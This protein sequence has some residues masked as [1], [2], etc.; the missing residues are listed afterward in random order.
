MSDWFNRKKCRNALRFAAL[1]FTF[2]FATKSYARPDMTPLG[3][4][5]ADKGSSF[6]HF[7]V[8]QFDS[9]DGKRHYRVWTGVPN[10]TPPASGFPILYLLDGNAVM[11]RISESLLKKLSENNPPVI[12]AVGYQ[13]VEPFALNARSFDYT[14]P[15]TASG[16]PCQQQRGRECGGSPFF[17]DLLEKT[18]APVAEQG[19]KIDRRKRGIWGHSLGGIYVLNAYLSSSLFTVFYSTSPTLNREYVGL[20]NTLGAVTEQKYDNKQLWFI[21]GSPATS[22]NPQAPAA[23]VQDKIR[24]TLSQ[25]HSRGLPAAWWL[26]PELTHGQTFNAGFQQALLNMSEDPGNNKPSPRWQ[27]ATPVYVSR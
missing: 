7:S 19:L 22:E 12:V 4:N 27:R 11:D 9:P 10:K 3:P 17:G 6:Y 16:K 23:D 24:A 26:Y 15:V 8:S 2:I 25:L 20:L 18:I 14:P 13:T 1:F 5:I 21:E